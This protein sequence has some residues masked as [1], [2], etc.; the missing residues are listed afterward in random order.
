[1]GRNNDP[2]PQLYYNATTDT[3]TGHVY[4]KVVNIGSTSQTLTVNVAGAKVGGKATVTTLKAASPTETNTIDNP[5]NIVPVKST[6][7]VSKSFKLPMAPYSI[8][9]VAM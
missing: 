5:R 7:K 9:V 6:L 8:V 2:L 3:A 1:M 4:L